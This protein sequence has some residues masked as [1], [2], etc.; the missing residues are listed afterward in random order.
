[1]DPLLPSSV[2]PEQIGWLVHWLSSDV[3]RLANII[4]VP[5][6]IL[7]GGIAWLL[8]RP[9]QRW[10]VPSAFAPRSL[11][12]LDW[13]GYRAASDRGGGSGCGA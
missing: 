1:M 7:T 10:M 13:V 4:Q 8:C 2:S 6:L 12:D 5:A 3:L 11:A 9:V